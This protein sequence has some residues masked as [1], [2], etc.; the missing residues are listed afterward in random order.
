MYKSRGVI[1]RVKLVVQRQNILQYHTI[2]N[3]VEIRKVSNN[4]TYIYTEIGSGRSRGKDCQPTDEPCPILT[5][6]LH[7]ECNE[8]LQVDDRDASQEQVPGI[9]YILLHVC[10]GR[11]SGSKS[12]K[13]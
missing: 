5:G 11:R 10:C 9:S 12:T 6:I 13:A 2:G 4:G 8:C 3:V 1:T 7:V